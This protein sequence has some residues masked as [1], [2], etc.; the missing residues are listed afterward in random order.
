MESNLHITA[1]YASVIT[2]IKAWKIDIYKE[3]IF[4]CTVFGKT[5]KEVESNT[6][7]ITAAPDLLNSLRLALDEIN[8]LEL[9]IVNNR[10]GL[11]TD[12]IAI[13]QGLEVIKKATE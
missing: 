10:I 12:S 1:A 7:L 13:I 5:K 9:I 11:I 3:E 4:Y 2:S 8:R 6:K